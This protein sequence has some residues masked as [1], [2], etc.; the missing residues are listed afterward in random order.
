MKYQTISPRLLLAFEDYKHGGRSALKRHMNTIGLVAPEG[1][2]KPARAMIFLRC[3]ERTSFRNLAKVGVRLNQVRGKLRTGIVALDSLGTLSEHQGVK[4]ITVARKLRPLMD[5]APGKVSVPAFRTTS[6][7]TG[8]GVIVGIVDSGIDPNHPAF[9]GRIL[10]IWDQTLPG[11][12]VPEGPY[13]LELSGA[14]L[15]GSRDQVG[16]G[17]HVAG[18]AAGNQSIYGGIAPGA[19][20][21]IVKTDFVDTHIADGIEYIFAKASSLGQA[22]VVNLSLGGH[23]DPHDGTDGLSQKI[24]ER[25]G[26]GRI[27]CC[28]AGNEG[29]DNI[30]AQVTLQKDEEKTI[31]F[32]VPE[33]TNADSIKQARLNGW[34]AGGDQVDVAVQGPSGITTPFQ[35]IIANENPVMTYTI[36]DGKVQVMTPGPNPTNGDHNFQVVIE[37]QENFSL[38][39]TGVWRLTLKARSITNGTVDI[40]TVD[41]GKRLDVVFTGTSVSSSMKVGSPGAAKSAVTVASY[42]TRI[43]WNDRQ[44]Q[45]HQ[46]IDPQANDTLSD[47]S[48][49]GPLRNGAHKP[50]VTAP[51]SWIAS[52]LSA[53]SPVDPLFEVAPGIRVMQGTSMATPIVTGIVALL[54]ER[55]KTLDPGEVKTLLRN[56]STIP[57]AQAGTFDPNWGFGLI[58]LASL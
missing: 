17:T 51:G 10:S 23:S 36:P 47:F 11:P 43:I 53:D 42:T 41:D 6:G 22:A 44:G 35:K 37:P 18:I 58:N 33:P 38:V 39:T 4:R 19:N 16:H 26:P 28:A 24:D 45:P 3:D 40:W 30:H 46:T 57:G 32:I 31:R 21:V 14:N 8:N 48:S 7:L 5:I 56:N 34:Y 55:K 9:A 49:N 29:L 25:T 12:G 52:C 13:G 50:D 1:T 2:P 15:T 27:V 54:L 20:Y